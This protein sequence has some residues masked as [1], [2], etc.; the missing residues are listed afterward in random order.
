MII[1]ENIDTIVAEEGPGWCQELS[2]LL[3]EETQRVVIGRRR[4]DYGAMNELNRLLREKVT[5]EASEANEVNGGS[6]HRF[7][8]TA[9]VNANQ[10]I[11]RLID[12]YSS[13]QRR[14]VLFFRTEANA[15]DCYDWILSRDNRGIGFLNRKRNEQWRNELARFNEGEIYI[16][17]TT[18]QDEK[19]I[20]STSQCLDIYVDLP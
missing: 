1:V 18:Y 16:L 14:M 6:R 2:S 17:L 15:L 20:D 4:T 13:S 8:H 3:G 7:I 9:N 5:I 10:A 19:L 11:L 12:E